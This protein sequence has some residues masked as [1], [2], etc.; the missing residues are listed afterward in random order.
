MNEVL[1]DA[2]LFVAPNRPATEFVEWFRVQDWLEFEQ[3]KATGND[4]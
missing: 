2:E 3:P 1:T 4:E